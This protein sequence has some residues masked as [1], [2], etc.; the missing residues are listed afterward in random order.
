MVCELAY[1][2]RNLGCKSAYVS[3]YAKY[4]RA[5]FIGG[6]YTGPNTCIP[7]AP[8]P[9]VAMRFPLGSKFLSQPDECIN[10]PLNLSIPGEDGNLHWLK[11]PI[12]VIKKSYISVYC[13]PDTKLSSSK[14]HLASVS[15]Q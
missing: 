12:A 3:L 9:I 7:E 1:L 13:C 4:N 14:R 6:L 5:C 2:G 10:V 8:F 11:C 15:S